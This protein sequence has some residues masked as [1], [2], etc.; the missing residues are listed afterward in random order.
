MPPTADIAWWQLERSTP[1]VYLGCRITIGALLGFTAGLSAG[2]V[3][4]LAY[5]AALGIACA[6]NRLFAALRITDNTRL[7]YTFRFAPR[8]YGRMLIS[9]VMLVIGAL[10][11]FAAIFGVDVTRRYTV[12]SALALIILSISGIGLTTWSVI[13]YKRSRFQLVVPFDLTRAVSPVDTLRADRATALAGPWPF[14]AIGLLGFFL[15]NERPIFMFS[16]ACGVGWILACSYTGSRSPVSCS[17]WRPAPMAD[18]AISFRC[19]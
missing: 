16:V 15:F 8:E 11:L 7:P 17:R 12:R 18:N 2:I 3:L 6:S 13:R 10:A 4:A 19:S 5:G 1:H 9:A 14:F